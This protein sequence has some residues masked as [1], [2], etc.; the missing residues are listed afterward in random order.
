MPVPAVARAIV[1]AAVSAG[2]PAERAVAV[3][4][5]GLAG[6]T[7]WLPMIVAHAEHPDALVRSAVLRA[8]LRL[9][10][11]TVAGELRALA[12]RPGGLGRALSVVVEGLPP[13]L[14]L[15]WTEAAALSDAPAVRRA[16]LAKAERLPP[17]ARRRLTDRALSDADPSVRRAASL[18]AVRSGVADA[19]PALIGAVLDG[20]HEHRTE[21]ARRLGE[22]GEVSAVPALVHV[23]SRDDGPLGAVAS[24]SLCRL[25]HGAACGALRSAVA[26]REV[27]I[28][29]PAIEALVAAGTPEALDLLSVAVAHPEVEVRSAAAAALGEVSDPAMRRLLVPLLADERSE[30]RALAAAALVDVEPD[31]AL[32]VVVDAARG[33]NPALRV[34][35]TEALAARHRRWPGA[36]TARAL[37]VLAHLVDATRDAPVAGPDLPTAT[38]ALDALLEVGPALDR[39]LVADAALRHPT[40]ELRYLAARAVAAGRVDDPGAALDAALAD[41]VVSVR[42]AAAVARLGPD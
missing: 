39:S 7:G 8:R 19:A 18:L 16:A 15:E 31:R 17:A 1:E 25:G 29:G 28:A 27:G 41:P 5:L 21:A 10:P 4:T 34:R 14:V 9:A 13:D 36:E 12:A 33:A 38:R 24:A 6:R 40:P 11:E 37:G 3:D 42:V 35:L 20:P 32:A 26:T 2:R 22:M 23:A 30:P